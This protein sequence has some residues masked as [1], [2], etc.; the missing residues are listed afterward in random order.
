MS[1]KISPSSA[2]KIAKD[3]WPSIN[4]QINAAGSFPNFLKFIDKL[5]SSKYL[6]EIRNMNISRLTE[7]ELRSAD[8]ENFSAG[9]I[10]GNLIL[11]VYAK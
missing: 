7:N 10:K 1:I 2:T 3:P 4:F 5:E 6:I 8:Y 11:K 9:D